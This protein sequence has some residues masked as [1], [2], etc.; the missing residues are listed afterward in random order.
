[1]MPITFESTFSMSIGSK[2]LI[3]STESNSLITP[4]G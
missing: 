3:S 1:M 2:P 4:A